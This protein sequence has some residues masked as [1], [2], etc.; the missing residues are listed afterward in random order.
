MKKLICLLLVIVVSAGMLVGCGNDSGE[1][2]GGNE[3]GNPFGDS[4]NLSFEQKRER[5]EY[6]GKRMSAT[7]ELINGYGYRTVFVADDGTVKRVG[8]VPEEWEGRSYCDEEE[9]KDVVQVAAGGTHTIGIKSDGTAVISGS[10]SAVSQLNLDG[11][12]DLIDVDAD[13]YGYGCIVGV[14]KDGSVIAE[15]NNYITGEKHDICMVDDWSD[16]KKVSMSGAFTVGL[17][18]DG[19][20]V[21][22]QRKTKWNTLGSTELADSEYLKTAE[23]LYGNSTNVVS[24]E[25]IEQWKDIVDISSKGYVVAGLKSDG[26]VVCAVATGRLVDADGTI[27][28]NYGSDSYLV[29]VKK[30]ELNVDDWKNII[31]VTASD[32]GIIGLKDDGTVVAVGV[33]ADEFSEWKDIIA[34]S[35]GYSHVV[36]LKK[37]GS[38]VKTERGLPRM[39]E[40]LNLDGYK[41]F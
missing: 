16:I 14:K 13:N 33:F 25:G 31:A 37:D 28:R 12:T 35:D 26:T 20:V 4:K 3:S 18:N 10:N 41:M 8:D 36:G 9:W 30:E 19:T 21:A 2:H 11:W 22:T 7:M 17:K 38:F 39:Q 34:I 27:L 5:A 1:K 40:E 15:G 32:K 24:F 6:F 29:A 23:K